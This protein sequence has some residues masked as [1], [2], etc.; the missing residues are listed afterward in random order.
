MTGYISLCTESSFGLDTFN[1]NFIFHNY[2]LT[3]ANHPS[4]SNNRLLNV[5]AAAKDLNSV[6]TF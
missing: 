4:C 3:N 2:Q 5:L 6:L 1:D